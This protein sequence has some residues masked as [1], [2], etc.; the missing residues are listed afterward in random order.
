MTNAPGSG[1]SDRTNTA[2]A[3]RWWWCEALVMGPPVLSRLAA[4]T[5]DKKYL[6][7]LDHEWWAT[8]DY[9][10]DPEEHLF[11]RDS[12]YFTQKEANGKKIFWGRGN[13]WVIAGLAR[14]LET[15]PRDWPARP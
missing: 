15:M 7:F 11:F 10:Y 8:S 5:G 13:G 6:E 3:H 1:E 12:R 14:V 2:A 4:A 9:L